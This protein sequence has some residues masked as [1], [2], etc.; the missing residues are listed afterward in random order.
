MASPM[1]WLPPNPLTRYSFDTRG[2]YRTHRVSVCL[3]FGAAGSG[4]LGIRSDALP[5][6]SDVT[7]LNQKRVEPTGASIAGAGSCDHQAL[8]FAVVFAVLPSDVL[9]GGVTLS[10]L[11]FRLGMAKAYLQFA[12]SGAYSAGQ[13]LDRRALRA[14]V[15]LYLWTGPI[16]QSAPSM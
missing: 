5:C 12:I 9:P 7:Y 8:R 1:R 11:C 3:E 4:I 10:P 14:S 13:H 16:R 6:T 15:C 2:H